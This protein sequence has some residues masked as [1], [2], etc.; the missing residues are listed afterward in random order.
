MIVVTQVC[1]QV[2]NKAGFSADVE[3]LVWVVECEYHGGVYDGGR[4]R[5]VVYLLM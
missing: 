4:A 1:I 3:V 5:F 2:S